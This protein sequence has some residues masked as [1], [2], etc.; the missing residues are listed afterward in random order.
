MRVPYEPDVERDFSVKSPIAL[1][2]KWFNDARMAEGIRE[3]NA[4]AVATAD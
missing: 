4:V 1:F 3:A 2:D